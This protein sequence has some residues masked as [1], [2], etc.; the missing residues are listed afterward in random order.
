M[1]SIVLKIGI[2]ISLSFESVIEKI[3]ESFKKN[4]CFF[5]YYQLLAV[6]LGSLLPVLT[7]SY[8]LNCGISRNTRMNEFKQQEIAKLI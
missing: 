4:G 1:I 8:S 2:N 6:P 3:D 7:I 5:S